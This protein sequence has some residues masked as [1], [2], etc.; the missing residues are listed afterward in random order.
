MA[1]PYYQKRQTGPSVTQPVNDNWVIN[2]MSS[3]YYKY[4]YFESAKTLYSNYRI[5][6]CVS[7]GS[8]ANQLLFP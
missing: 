2:L 6:V 4:H 5:Y 7:Y 3:S 1:S 8:H